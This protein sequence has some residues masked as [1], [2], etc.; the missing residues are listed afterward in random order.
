M[1]GESALAGK[2]KLQEDF[3]KSGKFTQ[4]HPFTGSFLAVVSKL[5]SSEIV[6]ILDKDKRIQ[7]NTINCFFGKFQ[8]TEF[9]FL[10]L[11][12]YDCTQISTLPLDFISTYPLQQSRSSDDGSWD[13]KEKDQNSI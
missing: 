1:G 3:P 4:K 6:S 5:Q 7:H 8:E 10:G 12:E 2:A 13:I 11:K 9:T